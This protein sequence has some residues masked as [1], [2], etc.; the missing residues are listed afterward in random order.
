LPYEQIIQNNK[1]NQFCH[2]N[3]K[4]EELDAKKA[5]GKAVKRRRESFVKQPLSLS[6]QSPD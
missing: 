1:E 4:G 5:P 3:T 6:I 2:T